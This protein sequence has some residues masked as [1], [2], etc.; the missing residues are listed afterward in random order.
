MSAEPVELRR[1]D[2]L[3]ASFADGE[4]YCSTFF[5]KGHVF[6]KVETER[7]GGPKNAIRIKYDKPYHPG[8]ALMHCMEVDALRKALPELSKW[9]K[10]QANE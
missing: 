9:A 7:D 10:E 4:W 5:S 1:R 8:P 6:I 3:P 2:K